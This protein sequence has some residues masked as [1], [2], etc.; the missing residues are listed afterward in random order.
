MEE[1]YIDIVKRIIKIYRDF[2]NNRI[3]KW[4]IEEKINYI[5]ELYPEEKEFI[6]KILKK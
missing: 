4:E 1:K 2:S 3:K 5:K 6:D